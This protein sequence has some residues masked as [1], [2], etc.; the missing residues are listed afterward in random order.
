MIWGRRILMSS[1]AE[2]GV[3]VDRAGAGGVDGDGGA[4]VEDA[5]VLD[6]G[7]AVVRGNARAGGGYFPRGRQPMADRYM[8]LPSIGLFVVVCWEACDLAGAW[9]KRTMILGCA[10]AVALA[11]CL[12][13]ASQ[14]LPIWRNEGTVVARIPRAETNFLGHANYAAY[15]M[16]HNELAK[17]EAECREAIRIV[18]SNTLLPG[19]LGEIL[20]LEGRLDEGVKTLRA[21]L[22]RS[23]DMVAAHLPLGRILL[24][25]GKPEAAA[26][27]FD[28]LILSRPNDPEAH[29]WRGN[30]LLA[31]KD[32]AGGVKEFTAALERNQIIRMR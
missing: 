13:V 24:Q 10:G 28:F 26:A 2:I 23:P 18:P 5:A 31:A 15:L 19:L 3:V 21:A 9:P 7:L 27:E 8:Y 32:T 17:A 22:D 4:V 11:G 25:Q 1:R 6:G 16:R 29:W 20:R 14:Q 30:A 12:T